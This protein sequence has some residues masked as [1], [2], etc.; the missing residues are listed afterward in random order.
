MLSLWEISLLYCYDFYLFTGDAETAL[1]QESASE[2]DFAAVIESAR[3]HF[4]RR[5]YRRFSC[6]AHALQNV[7]KDGFKKAGQIAELSAV[8]KKASKIVSKAHQS[9]LFADATE[10]HF[11][12]T[13][14]SP[15]DTRWNSQL[16]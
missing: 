11:H 2:V 7:V 5:K 13:I 12:R 14:P 4:T 16:K 3:L 10:Q 15:N 8:L 9:S 6:F 1:P